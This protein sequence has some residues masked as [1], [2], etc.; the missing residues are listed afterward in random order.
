MPRHID[1]S[2]TGLTEAEGG[3]MVSRRRPGRRDDA[4]PSLIPLL[5]GTASP[6]PDDPPM[7]GDPATIQVDQETEGDALAPARGI[8]FGIALSVPIWAVL[9]LGAYSLLS[10]SAIE[11]ALAVPILAAVSL[12][13]SRLR[14]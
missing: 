9:I 8:I 2:A 12:A 7:I 11:I 6:I 4:H 5:R 1:D 3:Q 14:N 10:V 13:V